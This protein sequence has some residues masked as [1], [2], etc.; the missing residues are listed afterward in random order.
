[1]VHLGGGYKCTS[2]IFQYVQS[3]FCQ[4]FSGLFFMH[5]ARRR[6]LFGDWKYDTNTYRWTRQRGGDL[7]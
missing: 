3:D 4:T 2:G 1:M 7:G 5:I 6:W